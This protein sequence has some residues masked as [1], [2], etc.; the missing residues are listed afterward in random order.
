VINTTAEGKI[1][2]ELIY[3]IFCYFLLIF[4]IAGMILAAW[5]RPS[6]SPRWRFYFPRLKKSRESS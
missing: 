4:W 6:M 2:S 3:E 1:M 5:I